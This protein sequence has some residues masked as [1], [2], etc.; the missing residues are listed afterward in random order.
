MYSCPATNRDIGGSNSDVLLLLMNDVVVNCSCSLVA[1][2]RVMMQQGL[3]TPNL[4]GVIGDNLIDNS[5]VV[6]MD[7]YNDEIDVT[8]EDT[9]MNTRLPTSRVGYHQQPAA[10]SAKRIKQKDF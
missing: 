10:W 2:Y 6:V 7:K 1:I 4:D 3:A 8:R 9:A 5:V